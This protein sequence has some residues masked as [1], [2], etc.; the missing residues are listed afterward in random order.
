MQTSFYAETYSE[1]RQKFLAATADATEHF[2]DPIID[3]LTIDT[4]IYEAPNPKNILMVVSGTHGVEGYSGSAVQLHVLNRF[5]SR[6]NDQ[7]TLVLIHALNPYGFAHD[8]RVNHHRVDLNRTF[9]DSA[10]EYT[11]G[12]EAIDAAFDTLYPLLTPRRSRGAEWIE[13][14]RF[15]RSIL[16]TVLRAKLSGTYGAV[17]NAI[18][19]GQY[20]YPD[21]PF[22]GGTGGEKEVEVFGRIL[23]TVTRGYEQLLLLDCHTGLGKRGE[24]VYFTANA[25]GSDA[26]ERLRRIE[27]LFTSIVSSG[28]QSKDIYEAK[29]SLLQY[30][31]RHSRASQSYAFGLD[32]GT[33]PNIPLLKRIIAENQVWHHPDTPEPIIRKVQ[34]HLREGFYPYD[35]AWRENTL[36]L[37]D[38]FLE[39]LVTEFGLD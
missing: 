26:F 34:E 28:K 19:G 25:H 37:Y 24:A 36:K 35:P 13:S 18:A 33:I 8:T 30:A 12:S 38:D 7:T 16:P 10:E 29:G 5:R 2:H 11:T 32:I 31:I 6:L 15:Y 1:A 22:Y 21:A 17:K 27:P 23:R 9:H 14:L 3:D 4:A 39:K 20:R